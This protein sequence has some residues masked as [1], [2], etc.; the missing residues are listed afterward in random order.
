MSIAKSLLAEFEI[1][2]PFSNRIAYSRNFF[3]ICDLPSVA[4]T[5]VIQFQSNERSKEEAFDVRPAL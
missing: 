4:V 1:Q 3:R 2:A 5:P